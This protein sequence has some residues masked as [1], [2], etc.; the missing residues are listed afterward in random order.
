VRRDPLSV[1]ASLERQALDHRRGLLVAA[2]GEQN[3]LRAA[4][5]EHHAA[6]QEAMTLAAT[7]EAELD[8]WGSLSRGNR[9]VRDAVERKRAAQAVDLV[10]ARAAAHAS[11]AELKRLEI[12]AERRAARRVEEA[13][14]AERLMLDELATLRHGRG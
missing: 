4:V 11:L 7:A 1:L 10:Q 13:E 2:Q 14:R 8:L 12:L 5:G 6:W 9:R 3:R